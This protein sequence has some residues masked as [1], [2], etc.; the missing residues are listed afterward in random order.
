MDAFLP[1]LVNQ[2]LQQLLDD[3][4]DQWSPNFLDAGPNSRFYQRSRAGLFCALRNE[5]K[6][7][8]PEHHLKI[9]SY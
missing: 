2:C 4:L 1:L 9:Q 3:A 8:V 7:P 6:L 5:K